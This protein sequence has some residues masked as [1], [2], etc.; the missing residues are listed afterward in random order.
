MNNLDNA[1]ADWKSWDPST[2]GQFG[3]LDARYFAAET[4]IRAGSAVRVLEIGFGNGAFLGWMKSIGGEVYGTEVNPLLNKRAREFLGKERVFDS[5]EDE[6]TRRLNGTITHVIAFDVV[7][8]VP[9]ELLPRFLDRARDLLTRK[10]RIILRFPNGDS[11]FGRITQ[12]GDPTHV[13][14]LGRQK[15]DYLARGSKLCVAEIRAPKLPVRD[16]GLR[17][18]IKRLIL[19]MSRSMCER[20]VSLLY[21]SGRRIPLDPNYVAILLH[22]ENSAPD[23]T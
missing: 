5:L 7:E 17:R 15:I 21:F 11:P 12:H 8:H 19:K 6:G 13:T 23:L 22:A 18:G 4:S 20:V 9:I 2:F 16:V 1:Y 10:G 14:T 3:V